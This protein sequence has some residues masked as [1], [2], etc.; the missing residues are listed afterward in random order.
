[1]FKIFATR[2]TYREYFSPTKE[3]AAAPEAK[4][5]LPLLSQFLTSS[6]AKKSDN[7]FLR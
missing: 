1:M 6:V 7:F 4:L 2:K 5:G 3:H